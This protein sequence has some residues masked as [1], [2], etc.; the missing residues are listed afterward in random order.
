MVYGDL[1]VLKNEKASRPYEVY[2]YLGSRHDK[3]Q[4]LAINIQEESKEELCLTH[5][6]FDELYSLEYAIDELHKEI[7][8]RKQKVI[9]IEMTKEIDELIQNKRYLKQLLFKKGDY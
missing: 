3:Q 4:I 7:A 9:T 1:F 2:Q 5:E 8:N 6:E